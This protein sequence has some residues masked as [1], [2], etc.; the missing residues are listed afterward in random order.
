MSYISIL[1]WLESLIGWGWGWA[2]KPV[3]PTTGL[4]AQPQP[5]SGK[6]GAGCGATWTRPVTMFLHKQELEEEE[7]KKAT[8]LQS[9]ISSLPLAYAKQY[10]VELILEKKKSWYVAYILQNLN[11]RSHKWLLVCLNPGGVIKSHSLIGNML[12]FD[13]SCSNSL[14]KPYSLFGNVPVSKRP[15][16]A[17]VCLLTAN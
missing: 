17:D 13:Y 16:K 4:L 7:E 10:S 15:D 9:Y 5:M 3:E 12:W 8:S 14:I 11:T 6:V 2:N 1:T